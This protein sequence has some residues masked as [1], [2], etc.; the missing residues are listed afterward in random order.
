MIFCVLLIC[1]SNLCWE[2]T[3]P[4]LSYYNSIMKDKIIVKKITFLL[5]ILHHFVHMKLIHTIYLQYP[6]SMRSLI[7]NQLL[8]QEVD[9]FSE[10]GSQNFFMF[11]EC[12]LF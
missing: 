1:R 3:L 10:L 4:E 5:L 7:N 8:T 12:D 2:E 9:P 6:Q 11:A